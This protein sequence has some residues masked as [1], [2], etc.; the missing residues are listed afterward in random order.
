MT[1]VQLFL[2]LVAVITVLPLAMAFG[3]ALIIVILRFLV[4]LEDGYF[5]LRSVLG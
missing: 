4:A 5:T 2:V 3:Y 1:P